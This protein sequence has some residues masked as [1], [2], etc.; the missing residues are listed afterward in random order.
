MT[1]YSRG[2]GSQWPGHDGKC[3]LARWLFGGNES[4]SREVAH[5]WNKGIFCPYWL[6]CPWQN[7]SREGTDALV[8]NC[9]MGATSPQPCPALSQ[10][11]SLTRSLF[12][13]VPRGMLLILGPQGEDKANPKTPS[14]ENSDS[15]PEGPPC[16]L[17]ADGGAEERPAQ[18][19]CRAEDGT[20]ELRMLSAFGGAKPELGLSSRAQGRW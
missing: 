12:W 6:F 9:E 14:R 5:P 8:G 18:P 17:W 3:S 16:R 1:I 10:L 2:H 19:R 13:G 11:R 20:L 7:R 15:V 4:V